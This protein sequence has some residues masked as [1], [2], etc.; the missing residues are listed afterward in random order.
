MLP[1]APNE[2]VIH[3]MAQFSTCNCFSRS[4]RATNS[5]CLFT[6]SAYF[7]SDLSSFSRNCSSSIS[8]LKN[9][10]NKLNNYLNAGAN[11]TKLA[12]LEV[13]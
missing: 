5:R 6:S 1:H 11:Y 2:F 4:T 7:S 12:P 13:K 9:E 10:S 8:I 3:L